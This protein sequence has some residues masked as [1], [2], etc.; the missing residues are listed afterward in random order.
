MEGAGP[1]GASKM[2]C[3]G[4]D[5]ASKMEVPAV[6]VDP[7]RKGV[8]GAAPH[9]DKPVLDAVPNTDAVLNVVPNTE[10][11]ELVAAPGGVAYADS[12][13]AGATGIDDPTGAA[14]KDVSDLLLPVDDDDDAAN[15]RCWWQDSVDAL[16]AT[17]I[18]SSL[19][20]DGALENCGCSLSVDMIFVRLL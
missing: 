1:D 14:L 2:E 19:P 15:G 8:R 4:P 17:D 11:P 10:V 6:G 7:N 9:T 5:G 12:E 18:D 13:T 20:D 16:T 3:A